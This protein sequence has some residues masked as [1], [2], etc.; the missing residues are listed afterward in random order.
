MKNN[1]EDAVLSLLGEGNLDSEEVTETGTPDWG[2]LAKLERKNEET[3]V[4]KRVIVSSI[5]F[6]ERRSANELPW[7]TL[8]S[9]A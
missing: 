2:R 9:R 7:N 1:L 8:A 3:R 4:A 6:A 5:R